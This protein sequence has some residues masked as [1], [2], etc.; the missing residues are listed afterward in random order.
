MKYKLQEIKFIGHTITKNGIKPDEAK[1]TAIQKLKTPENLK[2]LKTFLGMT[3][4]LSK[5]LPQL[6]NETRIFRDLEKKSA[7]WQWLPNHESQFKKIKEMIIQ[8]PLL[9]YFNPEK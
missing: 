1:I 5:F 8:A 6:S 3:N 4:Y 9:S 2:Q 7:R